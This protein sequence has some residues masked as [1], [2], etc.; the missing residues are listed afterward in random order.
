VCTAS[1]T[2]RLDI[3]VD[4]Q[5]QKT[6]THNIADTR[7]LSHPWL[8]DSEMRTWYVCTMIVPNS[9]VA[10]STPNSRLLR[11]IL[12]SDMSTAAMLLRDRRPMR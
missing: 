4:E 7:G 1:I 6:R 2:L 10:K 12:I 3:S 8:F 5:D 9:S 11:M